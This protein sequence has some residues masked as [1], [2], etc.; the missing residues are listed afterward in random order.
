ML[1]HSSRV[2]LLGRE[3]VSVDWLVALQVGGW[4]WGDVGNG[5]TYI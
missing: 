2:G 3:G 5:A 1:V 4:G